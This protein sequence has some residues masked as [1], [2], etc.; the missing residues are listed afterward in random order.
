[1]AKSPTT[2]AK[3][4][5]R[6]VKEL[7][8]NSRN[9]R[10]HGAEDVDGIAASMKEF[11]FTFPI[12]IDETDTILAGHGRWMAA[13]KLYEEGATLHDFEGNEIAAGTVPTISAKGW[14]E[15][16]K[17]AYMIADNKLAETSAWDEDKLRAALTD[18]KLEGY[19]LSLTGFKADELEVVLNGWNPDVR[20]E[21]APHLAG[22][23]ALIKVRCEMPQKDE[24]VQKINEALAGLPGVVIE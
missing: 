9:S 16:K 12:L 22:M 19:E 23:S 6:N 24:V 1:M 18:L 5:L 7:T 10:K 8:P 4:L 13:S 17:R 3:I 20:N 11:G 14:S 21:P 15:A 2:N